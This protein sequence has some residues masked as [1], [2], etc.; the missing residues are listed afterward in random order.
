MQ[1]DCEKRETHGFRR[2]CQQGLRYL[3]AKV[4]PV[5]VE[6]TCHFVNLKG[7]MRCQLKQASY[8]PS[9]TGHRR[10]A[11]NTENNKKTAEDWARIWFSKLAKFHNIK[12]KAEW[13]FT[14]DE[15][16][17][18]LRARLKNGT[19]AWKRL[20]IVKSLIVYR[21]MILRSKTPNLENIRAK[22][23]ELVAKEKSDLGEPFVDCT[24]TCSIFS[25]IV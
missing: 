6:C 23:Q 12:S 11:S 3:T 21:N 25:F 2:T 15:V 5:P 8:S 20:M 24:K 16:I 19:P 9:S 18:F 17:A 10:A 22:L 14:P 4:G 7:D 13:L 1:D